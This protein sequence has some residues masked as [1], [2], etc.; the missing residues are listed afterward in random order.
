[1]FHSIALY[2]YIHIEI[3]FV[4]RWLLTSTTLRADSADNTLM[5]F[6]LIFPREQDLTFPAYIFTDFVLRFYGSVNPIGSCKALSVYLTTL[7][8]DRLCPLSG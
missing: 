8:L 7:L 3:V 5:I 4:V 1:M 6:C 2:T